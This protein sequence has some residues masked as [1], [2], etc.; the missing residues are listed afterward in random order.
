MDT[1][2]AEE[3]LRRFAVLAGVDPA[4]VNATQLFDTM[5]A[6]Y[7]RERAEDVVVEEV[8]R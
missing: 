8:S 2:N 3:A 4:H 6:W 1:G 5:T 7:E